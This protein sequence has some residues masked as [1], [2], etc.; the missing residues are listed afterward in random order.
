MLLNRRF[1]AVIV[2]A[3]ILVI[4]SGSAASAAP[5]AR[6]TTFVQE[7]HRSNLAGIAAGRLA[8]QKGR[9]DE[10]KALGA[11]II[12]DHT[13]LDD[14][15]GQVAANLGIELPEVDAERRATARRLEAATGAEFDAL[16][17][18]TQLEAH[19]VMVRLGETQLAEGSDAAVRKLA[20]DAAPVLAAHQDAIRRAGRALGV[21]TSVDG[22]TGGTAA[23]RSDRT[24]G[25]LM[26][27]VG[28][29]VALLGAGYL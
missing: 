4:G 12:A 27:A 2:A 7:A 25:L 5:S 14:A 16:F 23:P 1:A 6:D 20:A 15:L 13:R 11:R 28:G 21:P 17:V 9:S 18:A 8:Q 10:V 3:L 24:T 26:I 29:L 22:G 19:R